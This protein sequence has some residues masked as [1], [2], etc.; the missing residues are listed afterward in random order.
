[1]A[2]APVPR[3]GAGSTSWLGALLLRTLGVACTLPRGPYPHTR[4]SPG[5]GCCALLAFAPHGLCGRPAALG[6]KARFKARRL[7]FVPSPLSPTSRFHLLHCRLVSPS[8]QL[9]LRGQRRRRANGD[10]HAR[11]HQARVRLLRRSVGGN[12]VSRIFAPSRFAPLALALLHHRTGSGL[13]AIRC[14][15][16]GSARSS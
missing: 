13:P 8:P 6:A 2:A 4:G 3:A 1:M 9:H 7:R 14:I 16:R 11:L 10:D 15:L 5:V 12:A